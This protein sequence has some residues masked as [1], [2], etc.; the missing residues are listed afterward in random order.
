MPP[1]G[2]GQPGHSG[3]TVA[4]WWGARRTAVYFIYLLALH[5]H[6][7]PIPLQVKSPFSAMDVSYHRLL[8]NG[9]VAL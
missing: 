8:V 3:A 7:L 5:R 9:V 4:G 2:S 6:N 1:W